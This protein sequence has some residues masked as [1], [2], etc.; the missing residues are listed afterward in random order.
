MPGAKQQRRSEHQNLEKSEMC[1]ETTETVACLMH[2]AWLASGNSRPIGLCERWAAWCKI[3]QRTAVLEGLA[4]QPIGFCAKPAL[5]FELS[6]V[7]DAPR[8]GGIVFYIGSTLALQCDFDIAM[9]IALSPSALPVRS[10]GAIM[11]I[12]PCVASRKAFLS[13]LPVA[14]HRR[15]S[16]FIP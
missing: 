15:N 5:A 13:S 9:R 4:S 6:Q 16:Y 1:H 2:L 12:L 8:S 3:A 11:E 10:I 14:S 7:K